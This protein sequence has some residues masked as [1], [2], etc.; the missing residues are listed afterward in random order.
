MSDSLDAK[1]RQSGRRG[2]LRWLPRFGFPRFGLRSLLL[3]VAAVATWMSYYTGR[4]KIAETTRAIESLHAIAPELY[5][6]N[7][8]EYACLA[9]D[10]DDSIREYH[11]YLPPDRKYKINLV[12]NKEFDQNEVVPPEFTAE[13][14]PGEHRILLDEQHD[15]LIVRVG[16]QTLLEVPRKRPTTFSS[17]STGASEGY[18]QQWHPIDAPLLL[19]RLNEKVFSAKWDDPGPGIILWI[20]RV[21]DSAQE[22]KKASDQ[23]K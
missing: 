11:C 12:A 23:K 16:E 8:D 1:L 3:L 6:R 5:V 2:L 10:R 20:E 21:K 4:Q 9:I 13:I 18:Q 19:V 15:K 7:P 17:S 22:T 14:P